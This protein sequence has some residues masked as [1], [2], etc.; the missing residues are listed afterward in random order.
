VRQRRA[1]QRAAPPDRG[2]L[3]ERLG[4]RFEAPHLLDEALTHGSALG[5]PG[6]GRTYERLE[7][8]GDRVLGLVVAHLLVQRFPDDAEGALTHRLVALVRRESLTAVA[9]G[10]DLGRWL[11]TS[12]SEAG[13]VRPA[14]LADCCEAV[15]GAIYLDG[16]FSAAQAFVARYWAPLIE[17]V[18]VPPRD[19]KMALQ[20][21]AHARAL[22]PPAYRVVATLGPAHA[23]TF[24]VEV[25]LAGQDPQTA[26]AATKRAAER[27]AAALMLERIQAD[28]QARC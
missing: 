4:H 15:I 1:R 16:G 7:F 10:L 19:A 22:T 21:W 24:T 27:A 26:A 23:T 8:L 3:E 28:D 14:I 2:A 11:R 18:Q 25:T 9:T 13:T 5:G 20:E 17:M 6:I 12:A